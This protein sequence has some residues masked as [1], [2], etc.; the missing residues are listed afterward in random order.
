MKLD[1]KF[2][3]DVDFF[4]SN[5][6]DDFL[7]LEGMASDNILDWDLDKVDPS[8]LYSMKEQITSK[9]I[10]IYPRHK[11][12]DWIDEFGEVDDAKILVEKINNQE[13]YQLWV[14]VKLDKK[15]PE[16]IKLQKSL[17]RGKKIGF[18]IGGKLVKAKPEIERYV[19]ADGVSSF[20]NIRRVLEVALDH[21]C[22]TKKP[23]NPRS[24]ITNILK[25]L[26]SENDDIDFLKEDVSNN[27]IEHNIEENISMKPQ[28]QEATNAS[29]ATLV[30]NTEE[31]INKTEADAEANVEENAENIE[32]TETNEIEV[33]VK[34]LFNQV[35][36]LTEQNKKFEEILKTLNVN[37]EDTIEKTEPEVEPV[38]E[39]KTEEDAK[40]AEEVTEDPIVETEPEVTQENIE[41]VKLEEPA[42]AVI[43]KNIVGTLESTEYEGV[44]L[45]ELNTIIKS[46]ISET[47]EKMMNPDKNIMECAEDFYNS[48]YVLVKN[49]PKLFMESEDLNE[50]YS[51]RNCIVDLMPTYAIVLHKLYN[52]DYDLV[53]KKYCKVEIITTEDGTVALREDTKTYVEKRW[54][55][56][57]STEVN[58][59]ETNTSEVIEKTIEENKIEETPIEKSKVIEKSMEDLSVDPSP[60]ANSNNNKQE[61]INKSTEK[62]FN[63]PREYFDYLLLNPRKNIAKYDEMF[64]KSL[65]L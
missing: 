14:K 12:M 50:E 55:A 45:D 35:A 3:F 9:D 58:K 19:N 21:I 31:V 53:K 64:A 56:V 51:I 11:N 22:I 10:A 38:T 46:Q 18:S 59:E 7:Y 54:V 24:W 36:E 2:E 52:E 1:N 42:E 13:V 43:S 33:D 30:E 29:E 8:C 28:A 4:K 17:K 40:T 37:K 44:G 48:V 34:A 15:E 23:A 39:D 62:T 20:R 27:N 61:N 26:N 57:A 65:I 47:I 49:N 60:Y 41:D 32:K 5:E 25:S 16:T 6:D 63:S